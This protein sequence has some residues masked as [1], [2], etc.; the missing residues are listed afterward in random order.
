MENFWIGSLTLSSVIYPFL[1]SKNLTEPSIED[2]HISQSV[3]MTFET[4]SLKF[5]IV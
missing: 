1:T 2:A 3:Q 4:E 5:L